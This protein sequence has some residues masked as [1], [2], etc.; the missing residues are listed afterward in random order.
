ML[1]QERGIVTDEKPHEG[2][3]NRS[4]LPICPN[5]EQVYGWIKGKRNNKQ[6]SWGNGNNFSTLFLFLLC[7]SFYP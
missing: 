1:T 3:K 4:P 6:K 2:I 5:T 7:L